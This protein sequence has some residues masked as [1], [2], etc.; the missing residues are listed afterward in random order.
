MTE[1][2][3]IADVHLGR[4]AKYLRMLGFDTL[5][6]TTYDDN[7]IIEISNSENRIILSRDKLLLKN[8]RVIHGIL[9]MSDAPEDQ[10]R[11]VVGQLSLN[12]QVTPFS[13]CIVCNHAL[14]EV[15]KSEIEA[16]L[17]ERTRQYYDTFRVC[18]NCGRVYWE[19]S[20]FARMKKL[21]ESFT[22]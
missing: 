18:R 21:A 17:P 4:M 11:E 7:E 12:N 9:I 22:K 16:V 15:S 2:K 8:K 13:R 20:H 1:P 10:V 6:E 14:E 5:Y 3:F 19:G